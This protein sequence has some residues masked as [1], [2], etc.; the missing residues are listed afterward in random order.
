MPKAGAVGDGRSE[1]KRVLYPQSNSRVRAWSQVSRA[2]Q[3]AN[4]C[5]ATALRGNL[6]AVSENRWARRFQCGVQ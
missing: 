4:R 5:W 3:P 1:D 6:D 2:S